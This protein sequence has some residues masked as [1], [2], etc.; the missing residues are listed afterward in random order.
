MPAAPSRL[1][2]AAMN[3]DFHFHMIPRFFLDELAEGNP[4]GKRLIRE[5]GREFLQ[6]GPI[7]F[8]MDPDH[9]DTDTILDAMDAMRVDLA[10]ISPSPM[11]FHSNLDGAAVAPLHRR[12]NDHLQGMAAVH[13]DRFRPLGIVPMQSPDL[14]VAEVE[15]I[16]GECGMAGV[17]IETNIA[18]R[19]LSDA[20]FAPVFKAIERRSGVVFL[21]PAGI[22][23][24]DRLRE[25]YLSNLI[26]NPTDTA[27]AAAQLIFGGVLDA[28]PDL[29][30]VLPHGGGSTPA[31]CGR[32]DHGTSVRPELAHMQT[33]PSSLAK[34]FHY[35]SLTHSDAA[36]S[37]LLDVAGSDRIVLGSDHPYDM[38]ETNP[39]GLI[40]A[41]GDLDEAQRRA[42]LGGNALRLLGLDPD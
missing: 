13:P 23:G 31:L 7:R 21:H 42:I 18:G 37:L 40:E 25:Y 38:G 11:L 1:Q 41:R 9:Y 29:D 8:P 4:W 6:I 19:P 32:W 35:D 12:V 15:R 10:A 20:D 22:L 26:G 3:V 14:A 17:E 16:L 34:R 24:A 39:V 2:S 27:A 28:C 5:A 33:P 30:I 36:L